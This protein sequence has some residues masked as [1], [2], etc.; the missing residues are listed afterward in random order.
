MTLKLCLKVNSALEL[1]PARFAPTSRSSKRCSPTP[2]LS[3]PK[4]LLPHELKLNRREAAQDLIFPELIFRSENIWRRGLRACS[5]FQLF[6]FSF[7]FLIP[8]ARS[9]THSQWLSL[10][11]T[12]RF[13]DEPGCADGAI[14]HPVRHPAIQPL[15]STECVR[16]SSLMPTSESLTS[17]K[18]FLLPTPDPPNPNKSRG[19]PRERAPERHQTTRRAPNTAPVIFTKQPRTTKLIWIF[20]WRMRKRICKFVCRERS[21]QSHN[22]FFQSL[23]PRNPKASEHLHCRQPLDQDPF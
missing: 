9:T 12:S 13:G 22:G 1:A 8:I 10:A 21:P 2:V 7:Y 18:A 20:N 17:P 3:L 11:P 5:A 19:L 16:Q 4:T 23:Q 15:R 6:I 14:P